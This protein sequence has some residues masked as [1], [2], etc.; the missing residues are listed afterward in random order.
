MKKLILKYIYRNLRDIYSTYQFP[1][2]GGYS[3]FNGVFENFEQAVQA[4]PQAK[5]IGYN[6][7]ELAE[8][9]RSSIVHSEAIRSYDYPMIFWLKSILDFITEPVS[10]FDFGGNVGIHFYAYQKYI[11]YPEKLCWT[12]F[13]VPEIIKSGIELAKTRPSSQLKFTSENSCI[14][15]QHIFIASG[16]I[17]YVKNLSSLLQPFL[18][19]PKH[20]LL[21][22]IPLYEG[23]QFVTLQNGGKVFYPQYVFNKLTFIEDLKKIGYDLIDS[24]EDQLDSCIIPFYPEKSVPFYYGFY[25]KLRL[26]TT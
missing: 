22:R 1:R 25:L 16:S 3:S 17:Q 18:V 7:A 5:S 14:E 19:K 6:N 9:Y 15:N 2:E 24:W 21:N 23:E 10:I 20:L 26:D 8:E 11:K 12:V 13:D 4:A